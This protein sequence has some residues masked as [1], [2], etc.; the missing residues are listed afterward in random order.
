MKSFRLFSEE[1]V[2]TLFT[3][4]GRFSPPTTGHE[5]LLNAVASKAKGNTYRIYA[6]QSTDPKK[7]P[8]GYADKV[9]FM[10]KMFPKH[11]RNI[12]IDTKVKTVLDIAAKAHKDGFS[13]FVLVVGSDRI[14]TFVTLLNRYNGVTQK[15][16]TFYEFKDGIKV[17]SAGDR[18]PDADGVK[19]MSASKM[20]QAAVDN[21]I[22]KFSG[23]LPKGFG[24]VQ[25]LFNAVRKGMGLRESTSF[26][27]HVA[28]PT[29]SDL[30]E[31]YAAGET[32]KVGSKVKSGSETLTVLERKSNFVICQDEAGDT[33]KRWLHSINEII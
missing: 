5:K 23:G 3:T 13:E 26:R 25:E 16:G 17:V 28:L 32:F 20:R 7:N 27:R 6:S 29:L 10:R 2:K 14:D 31:K 4:F 11:A 30:R 9:K 12:L 18:D 33:T 22:K 1:R 15:N 21:D 19:G 24:E 8:L